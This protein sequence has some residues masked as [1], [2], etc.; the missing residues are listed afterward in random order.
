MS[1]KSTESR[2]CHSNLSKKGVFMQSL[3]KSLNSQIP[4][5]CLP[6]WCCCDMDCLAD[7]S[8][9]AVIVTGK[10][11]EQPS[12]CQMQQDYGDQARQQNPQRSFPM[13]G[14]TIGLPNAIRLRWHKMPSKHLTCKKQKESIKSIKLINFM[15]FFLVILPMNLHTNGVKHKVGRV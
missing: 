11:A 6:V 5:L 7:F 9:E 12:D 8:E 1:F 2:T 15:L 4:T 10:A 3:S 14:A 13:R